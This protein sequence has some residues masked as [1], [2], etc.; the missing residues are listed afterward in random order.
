MLAAR[1]N[2]NDIVDI[3]E[4]S[5][6][7]HDVA[8]DPLMPMAPIRYVDTD[9]LRVGYYEVGEGPAVVLLHGFPY[10]IHAYGA[11]APALAA[12]G[13]RVIIPYLRGYGA[14][15]YLTPQT[16]RSGE[17]AAL[18]ADLLGLLD[19]LDLPDAVLA[20]F[21][22]GARVACSVAAIWPERCRGI[23]SVGGYA[24]QDVV[25]AGLPRPPGAERALWHQYYFLTERGRSGLARHR[26]ALAELLWREWSPK[27]DFSPAEFERT[28]AAFENPDWVD[29]VVHNYRYRM[30]YAPG[31][32]K[33]ADLAD[34]L[35]A[36]PPVEVPA[37]TV[38]GGAHGVL[39][40]SD[41]QAWTGR[42]LGP[43]EHRTVAGAGHNVPQEQ[44]E[45]FA[46]AVLA[47]LG[48]PPS[49]IQQ[50]R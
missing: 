39:S 45:E 29:T 36:L 35:A 47:V 48:T 2:V 46:E 19:A 11:V 14:T 30:G 31:A 18:A 13:C 20:G 17:Q 32:P 4:W 5:A 24:I 15:R 38:D 40:A 10:D 6:S 27:W 22:W 41:G 33:Y 50:K 12:A 42:F 23:V 8:G 49:P 3:L 43:W 26:R 16:V 34:R 44:P 21:D 37:I 1:Q 9:A 7:N 25:G 28:A